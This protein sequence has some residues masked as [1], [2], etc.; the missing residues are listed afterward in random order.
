[1]SPVW[2]T[3][4]QLLAHIL[5]MRSSLRQPLPAPANNNTNLFGVPQDQQTQQQPPVVK[6]EEEKI[7][8]RAKKLI[9]VEDLDD[10]LRDVTAIMWTVLRKNKEKPHFVSYYTIRHIYPLIWFG[11]FMT[12][13]ATS[14]FFWYQFSLDNSVYFLLYCY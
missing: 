4:G 10:N 5:N 13:S 14:E 2:N 3:M 6:S 12:E 9:H 8:E 7:L 11:D 1:M